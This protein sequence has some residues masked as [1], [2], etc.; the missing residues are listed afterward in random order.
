M[1]KLCDYTSNVIFHAY[2]KVLILVSFIS[3]LF[4]LETSG[5]L[6][7]VATIY[8]TAL[9][10]VNNH[11]RCHPT[12]PA[13]WASLPDKSSE[14]PLP[15]LAD[16]VKLLLLMPFFSELVLPLEVDPSSISRSI[17]GLFFSGLQVR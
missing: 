5:S 1:H 14:A 6:T 2:V 4:G 17:T 16:S 10:S 12:R 13:A 11:W 9:A 15:Y 8:N 7:A 3:I